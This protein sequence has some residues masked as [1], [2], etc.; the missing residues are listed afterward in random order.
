VPFGKRRVSAAARPFR[1]AAL[2]QKENA[3]SYPA[4]TLILAWALAAF[5]ML[6]GA[7]NVLARGSTAEEYRRW[8]YPDWFHFVTGA[9]EFTTAALL[10]LTATRLL[11]AGLGCAIMLAAAATVIV[12]RE[13]P[14]AA[15][16]I[17]ALVLLIVVGWS[18]L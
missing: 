2:A 4:L 13:Y 3:M 7:I 11:G 17:I 18:A 1:P 16:P 8:G 6:G 15:P 10:V 9:L 14:R 5:F 12:H